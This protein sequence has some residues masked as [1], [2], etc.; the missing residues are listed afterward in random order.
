MDIKNSANSLYNSI[1]NL[2]I[3]YL[4]DNIKGFLLNDVKSNMKSYIDDVRL[5]WC[6]ITTD[7]RSS[8]LKTKTLENK[9][10]TL[11]TSNTAHENRKI[12]LDVKFSFENELRLELYET[13]IEKWKYKELVTFSGPDYIENLQ[14]TGISSPLVNIDDLSFTMDLEEI[15][16][17][18]IK[19]ESDLD[20]SLQTQ[21]KT[22]TKGGL[23]GTSK[24]PINVPKGAIV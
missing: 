6:T 21:L 15:E 10:S 22:P 8:Q 3:K 23:Q 18:T 5:E 1:D 14:I 11:I 4:G 20:T 24:S 9:D 17:A 12:S 16:F 2:S 13:L 19:H 7:T